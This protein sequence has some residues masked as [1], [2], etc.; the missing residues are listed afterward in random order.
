M[1]ETIVTDIS[2]CKGCNRCINVCPVSEANIA[3][4]DRGEIKVR[5]D[6]DKCIACGACLEA[7]QHEARS[8]L[9]DTE[10]FFNDLKRGI[11]ISAI[12]APAFRSN[13]SDGGS[14]LAWLKTLGVNLIMDVSLGA[15]I[16]TWAHIRYIERNRPKTLI[17]QPCPAI[18]SYIEKYRTG[19]ISKLSPVQS[20]MLCTAVF[21]KKYMNVTD[22]IAAISPCA[23]KSNEFSELGFDGYNVTFK[24]LNEYINKN[25]IF[26]PHSDF[27]FDNINSSLGKIYAMPGGL[28]ENIEF[29]LG[30][31]LRIDRSEGQSVVYKQIDDFAKEDSGNLPAVFDVLN[32]PEGCNMGT[33][34]NQ[35]SSV[36]RINR[37][38]DEQRE[39][40]GKLYQKT[41][42]MQFTRLF[43]LFDENLRIDDFTR[44][45]KSH[46]INEIPCSNADI[47]QAFIRLGKTTEEQ[48]AHN[49]YACGSRTCREMAVRIAKNIN[50]P[51][52]CVEKARQ[53]IMRERRAFLDEQNRS[54][55]NL[56]CISSEAEDIREL[57]SNVLTDLSNVENLIEQYNKMVH[58]VNDI[59]LQTQ[60]LS[61][62]AAVEAARAGE[63]GRGF[64]VVANAIRDLAKQSQ[65]SVSDITDTHLFAKKTISAIT[66][67]GSNVDKFIIKISDYIDKISAS[68]SGG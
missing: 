25:H 22:K 60:L 38:M 1:K 7:C 36:F 4:L 5:I 23:A 46:Y 2:K 45:Y 65:E 44:R 43:K 3:F 30:K 50:V 9:D 14:V 54:I 19:L 8:Y 58:I 35:K 16:C 12:V 48:R 51:E 52:N 10:R 33:G 13:F 40:N 27:R 56:D 66:D 37:I 59:V 17:T 68:M 20:P 32:C 61:L 31:S 55:E 39:A 21:L 28:K 42:E 34:C 62:N 29:Y 49:C 53:N 26:I 15:D 63:A 47:E 11:K 57:F 18:V 64:S 6:A 41:I 67:A 24:K